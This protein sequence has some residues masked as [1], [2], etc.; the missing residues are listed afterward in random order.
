M[1]NNSPAA[2][3]LNIHAYETLLDEL[4]DLRI[5]DVV[6]NRLQDFDS[7]QMISHEDMMKK[8]EF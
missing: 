7:S 5:E 6:R 1:K 4:E 2:V 8:F 3:L